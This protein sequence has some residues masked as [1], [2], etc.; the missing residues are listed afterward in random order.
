MSLW[1]Q[2]N[3][4]HRQ[5][6][7]YFRIVGEQYCGVKLIAVLVWVTLYMAVI[8]GLYYNVYVKNIS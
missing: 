2:L 8:V 5:F 6:Q 1:G 4:H 7:G 3:A